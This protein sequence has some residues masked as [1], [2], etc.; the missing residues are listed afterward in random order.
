MGQASLATFYLVFGVLTIY[1]NLESIGT[2]DANAIY[3]TISSAVMDY[4]FP[5]QDVNWTRHLDKVEDP[6]QVFSWLAYSFKPILFGEQETVSERSWETTSWNFS[7]TPATIASFN[8]IL[9][10]RFTFKRWAVEHTQGVFEKAT[11]YRLAG[12]SNLD[13]YTLN[14]EDRS[15]LCGPG[16]ANDTSQCF[17]WQTAHSF[18]RAGGYTEFFD[19]MEGPA[20][21]DALLK[22]MRLAGLFDTLMATCTVDMIVYNA[23]VEMF[24][25]YIQSFS[26]DFCGHI[27]I[28]NDARSFNLNVFNTSVG[29]YLLLYIMR[30]S[31]IVMLVFF[32][33]IEIHRMWDL[34]FVA[35]MQ[36]NGAVTDLISITTSFG[37]LL[38]Y[39]L[40]EQMPPY[41]NFQFDALQDV[42]ARTDAYVSLCDVARTL[43]IQGLFIAFNL[44]VVSFRTISLV[45]GLH[46]NLGLILKV[47]HVSTPNFLSFMA[48]F[49]MLLTGFV[50]TS[51][52]AFGAGY[53]EMSSIGLCIY[54]SFA[55]LSGDV[56]FS[57]M[58]RVDSILAPI[59]F[60]S[61]YILFYLVL[62]NIFVTLLMSGYDIVDYE[63]QK[64]GQTGGE[65]NPLVL[66]FEELKNDV[67]GTI[68]RYGSTAI[69]YSRIC[70]DPILVSAKAVFSCSRPS[71]LTARFKRRED[72][73]SGTILEQ[74]I[75]QVQSNEDV[76]DANK[77]FMRK[78]L[79]FLTMITFLGVWICLVTLSSRGLESYLAGQATL[80]NSVLDVRFHKDDDMKDF[81]QIKTFSDVKNWAD[82]AIVGL[83]S[84]PVCAEKSAP[85]ASS[86]WST[87]ASCTSSS[88]SQQLLNRIASWNIGFLNTTFVR[89]TIQP[90]CF[91]S[92]EG[93]WASGSPTM[94]KTPD[95][96]C[97]NS[98]CTD[99][100]SSE[101]CRTADGDLLDASN[102]ANRINATLLPFGEF[103]YEAPRK[104]LGPF[105][106]LGGLAFSLGVTKEQ[107]QQMLALLKENRW[108]TENS[109]S[110]VFDWLTYNGNMDLFTHNIVGFSL[111][112]TGVLRRSSESHSFSMN[113]AAGGGSFDLHLLVLILFVMYAILLLYQI[114]DMFRQAREQY[115]RSQRRDRPL[116]AF[117]REY[118]TD[119][120]NLIDLVTVLIS[121]ATFVCF[122]VFAL[123]GFRAQYR[124]STGNAIGYNDY[125][126]PTA[127]VGYYNMA[128]M[129]DPVRYLED[130]WYFFK[131]F[132]GVQA[133]HG[134]FLELA[135]LNSVCAG[136]RTIKT[137]N[138]FKLVDMFST[139]N[140]KSNRFFLY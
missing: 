1:L 93:R 42:N 109:A 41:R 53:S 13:P 115:V 116:L 48:L 91:V 84:D 5:L 103:G 66:I 85:G 127:A 56:V 67:V 62:I 86:E 124:F 9:L 131:E 29:K 18:N 63:L 120:W 19:P 37:V 114:V 135:A 43:Q 128:H 2:W 138:R 83:Y 99:V 47:L 110:M 121:V 11:P 79:P 87:N 111:L 102:L 51:F 20:A 4:P 80:R 65:K 52:F 25:Q 64:S 122:I 106:M 27:Q 107:C 61:F 119:A 105:R 126:V 45:S 69:K 22:D 50:L 72:L 74:R 89:L 96:A 54:E 92:T 108:F 58:N 90:A 6:E 104:D 118:F 46:S 14:D 129:T 15:T 40:I 57:H 78:L 35:A 140:R 31:C 36:Q 33:L 73:R 8:R 134:V 76:Q 23:N 88:N 17:H 7:S 71:F 97:W 30:I 55:M 34:G 16:N 59:Y 82:T 44:L 98:I 21:Y 68:L 125:A 136:F 95:D 112:Q 113:V 133:T 81:N 100:F 3:R 39:W 94:R 123:N 139:W 32:S 101:P 70:L 28:S 77:G 38:S 26:F 10:V 130:D 137:I 49:G 12:G 75:S 60:F 117:V 132:E 24:L